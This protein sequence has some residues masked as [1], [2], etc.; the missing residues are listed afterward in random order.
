MAKKF[1]AFALIL[2][3]VLLTACAKKK[4]P[5][6]SYHQKNRGVVQ[7]INMVSIPASA[8]NFE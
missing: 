7:D 4:R 1:F 5:D 3:F 8:K 2:S 6:M